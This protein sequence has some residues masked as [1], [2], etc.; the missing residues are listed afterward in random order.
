MSQAISTTTSGQQDLTRF[1]RQEIQKRGD[2]STYAALKSQILRKFSATLFEEHKDM[3]THLLTS[4]ELLANPTT[5]LSLTTFSSGCMVCENVIV[6]GTVSFGPG[7]IVQPCSQFLATG[8]GAIIIGSDN[9]FEEQCIVINETDAD[10]V[11]GSMNLFQVGCNI[12][13]TRIGNGNRIGVRA[14]VGWNVT[15]GDHGLIVALQTVPAHSTL[16]DH[17]LVTPSVTTARDRGD[18]VE[19]HQQQ[20]VD[21]LLALRS[22]SSRTCVLNFHKLHKMNPL[23]KKSN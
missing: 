9:I 22:P 12:Q 6:R 17:C 5:D 8:T 11:I 13:A 18:T 19:L 14:R 23:T 3:V 16:V 4:R 15:M 2:R 21:C 7:T 20:M 10:M 1:V